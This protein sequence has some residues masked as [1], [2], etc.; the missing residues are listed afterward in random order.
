VPVGVGRSSVVREEPQSGQNRNA[1][2]ASAPQ[3]GHVLPSFAPQPA[4]NRWL[5]SFSNAQAGQR[6]VIPG[7][8]YFCDRLVA[9]KSRKE[10]DDNGGAKVEKNDAARRWSSRV[11]RSR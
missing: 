8:A 7:G 6:T 9:R 3:A 4:Q 5:G 11:I 2:S 10:F 1:G